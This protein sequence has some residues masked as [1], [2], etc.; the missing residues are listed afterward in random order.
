MYFTFNRNADRNVTYCF[1]GH[2]LFCFENLSINF[3]LRDESDAWS[4]GVTRYETL[5]GQQKKTPGV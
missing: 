2:I 3:S 4:G 5:I 1:T